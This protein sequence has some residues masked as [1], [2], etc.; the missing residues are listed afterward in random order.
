M[1]QHLL[2]PYSEPV[3]GAAKT[4]EHEVAAF[5]A[6]KALRYIEPDADDFDLVES[7]RIAKSKARSLLY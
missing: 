1:L 6:L 3:S 2:R 5:N 4:I 7:L